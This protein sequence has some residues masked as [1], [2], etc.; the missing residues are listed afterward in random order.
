VDHGA[1][2]RAVS[3]AAVV[4]SLGAAAPAAADPEA[5]LRDARAEY[6]VRHQLGADGGY[7]SPWVRFR[8]GPIPFAIPNTQARR[9]ALP[10]HDLHHIA[11]GYDTNWT[12]EGEIAAWELGAGCGQYGVAWLINLG[13]FPIGLVIAPRRTWRAFVRGRGSQSLYGEAWQ[14]A[15]LDLTVSAMRERLRLPTTRGRAR[16]LDPLL[17]ASFALPGAFTIAAIAWFARWIWGA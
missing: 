4:R 2:Q 15:W 9:R 8:I 13:A 12:G 1:D 6:F 10:L 17:F 7:S 16:P 5:T 11:T 3:G 14:E